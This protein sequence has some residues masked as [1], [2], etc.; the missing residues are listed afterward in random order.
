M[1]W[2]K[3]EDVSLLMT[4]VYEYFMQLKCGAFLRKCSVNLFKLISNTFPNSSHL[5]SSIIQSC[6]TLLATK[7]ILNTSRSLKILQDLSLC[8]S[9]I[10]A[11]P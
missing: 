10:M 11:P 6:V 7:F 5:V 4:K 8:N 1:Q 3:I 9:F 2:K